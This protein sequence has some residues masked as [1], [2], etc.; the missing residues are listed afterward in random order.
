MRLEADDA[1]AQHSHLTLERFD[2]GPILEPR[3]LQG[4][5]P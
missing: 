4:L 3:L 5:E 1:F 2:L